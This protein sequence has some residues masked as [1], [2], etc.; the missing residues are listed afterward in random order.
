MQYQL[1]PRF[2]LLIDSQSK[3]KCFPAAM[4]TLK[5]LIASLPA[6]QLS[7]EECLETIGSVWCSLKQEAGQ[8]GGEEALGGATLLDLLPHCGSGAL[9]SS[10]TTHVDVVVDIQCTYTYM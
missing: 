10:H 3:A 6:T 7:D 8:G 4:A 2:A 1:L 5:R 9:T